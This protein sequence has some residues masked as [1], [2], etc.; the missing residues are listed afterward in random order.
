M[1]LDVYAFRVS[2]SVADKYGLSITSD[3]KS[4]NGALENEGKK[5]FKAQCKNIVADLEKAY[6]EENS[7]DYEKLYHKFI[8]Q[9]KENVT[10]FKEYAFYLR[11]LGYDNFNGQFIGI[12]TPTDAKEFLEKLHKDIVF[13]VYQ[14]YFRKVNFIF[15]FFS[16]EMIDEYYAVVSKSRIN[17]LIKSCDEVLKDNTK[18]EEILPTTSGFFF[19]S[20]DYDKYYFEDVKNCKEQMKKL[21]STMSDDD[22][23]LWH[24]SW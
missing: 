17:D 19:G 14:A 12:K 3:F 6:K 24:F 16:D 21:H 9:L 23:V 7:V 18:A 2:K 8:L 15:Q 11:S 13:G 20:T 10:F 22:F 4:I 1:G 5:E